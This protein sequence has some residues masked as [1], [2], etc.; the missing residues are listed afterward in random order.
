[1][2]KKYSLLLQ[3]AVFYKPQSLNLEIL[4]LTAGLETQFLL[5]VN[6]VPQRITCL[7]IF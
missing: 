5:M 2:V 7:T 6:G 4:Q 1:M 3:H